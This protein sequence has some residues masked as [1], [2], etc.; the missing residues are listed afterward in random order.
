MNAKAKN[1]FS[2]VVPVLNAKKYL[3]ACLESILKSIQQYGNAEL[4]VLDNGSVDGSYEILLNE[5]SDRAR[6][7]QIRG[8]PVGVLRN[9]GAMSADGEFV[10]F[11][12]SDCTVMPDYFEQALA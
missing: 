5:Y 1:R 8:V 2:V 12:D 4:I 9:R 10:A 3:R 11:I 7:Q 6:I